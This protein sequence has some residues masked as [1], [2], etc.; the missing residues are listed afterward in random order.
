MCMVSVDC[1][2]CAHMHGAHGTRIHVGLH[3][4]CVVLRGGGELRGRATCDACLNLYGMHGWGTA[5]HEW[6]C[7]V[8]V[9][10]MEHVDLHGVRGI[11]CYPWRPTVRVELHGKF[12]LH[13]LR[14]IAL[15]MWNRVD[16]M[17]CVE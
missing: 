5:G 2:L 15:C 11:G 8:F 7:M 10:C 4:V 3:V 17:V 16:G 1:K 12:E 6:N 14:G 13:G 9:D